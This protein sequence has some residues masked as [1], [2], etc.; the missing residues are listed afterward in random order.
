MQEKK[1]FHLNGYLG[2]VLVLIL[3]GIGGELVV[4]V[5]RPLGGLVIVVALIA[6]SS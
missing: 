2:L 5:N 3:L 1:V 4:N 6:A